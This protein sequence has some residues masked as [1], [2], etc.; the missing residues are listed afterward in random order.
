MSA[1]SAVLELVAYLVFFLSVF[2]HRPREAGKPGFDRWILVVVAA[3]TGFLLTL[4]MNLG[5]TIYLAKSGQDPAFPP[6]FDQRFLLLMA[7]GFLAPFVWGFSARWMP[8]FLGLQP[9]RPW[10]SLAACTANFAGVVSALFGL[11]HPAT[12][13][14]LAGAG[15]RLLA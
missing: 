15:Q 11:T 4:L 7:W 5:G 1:V 12:A 8:I 13:L 9:L 6:T 2:S 14:L 10:L 3:S